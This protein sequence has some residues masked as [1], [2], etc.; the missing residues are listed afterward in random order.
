MGDSENADPALIPAFD[1]L[2]PETHA[3]ACSVINIESH[4]ELETDNI[5]DLSHI[6]YL[7]PMFSSPAVSKGKYECVQDGDTV[8]SKRYISNDD[9]PP[10]LNEA[11]GFKPGQKADRWLN[12]RW[13][14]P[15]CMALYA[16]AVASGNQPERGREVAGAH[17]FTPEG[18]DST[19]YFFA[20]AF[21][22]SVG[23]QAQ[24]MADESLAAGVGP[25]GAFT[26]EDKPMIEAQAR[27]MAGLDFWSLQ[28]HLL[29]IDTAAVKARRVLERRISQENG[30]ISDEIAKADA[31]SPAPR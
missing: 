26:S 27:N 18:A 16:G 25:R 3:V 5:M 30:F 4:Y 6:E 1:F 2:V 14:A 23:P 31:D 17:I 8:W 22:K 15:A 29:S 24:Q 21:P 13:E 28:P 19:H 11:F 9:L 12:V 7:H 20:A 10:F